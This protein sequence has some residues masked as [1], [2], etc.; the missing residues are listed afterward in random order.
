MHPSLYLNTLVLV[1]GT[2]AAAM[3]VGMII[4][5]SIMLRRIR[6]LNLLLGMICTKAFV[7]QHLPYWKPW[8][9]VFGFNLQIRV[10][11]ENDQGRQV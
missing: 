2:I 5:Y 11:P 9:D 6:L 8:A 7:G 10:T 4:Y 3:N 1:L